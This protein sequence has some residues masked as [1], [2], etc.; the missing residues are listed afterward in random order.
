MMCRDSEEEEVF[1]FDIDSPSSRKRSSLRRNPSS[2]GSKAVSRSNS[3][4]GGGSRKRGYNHVVIVSDDEEVR[5]SNG[6]MDVGDVMGERPEA[7]GEKE[8]GVQ[9]SVKKVDESTEELQSR[10]DG[11]VQEPINLV[12]S[13]ASEVSISEQS[14]NVGKRVKKSDS[15]VEEALLDDRSGGMRAV[16]RENGIVGGD[17]IVDGGDGIADGKN[18][19][20]DGEETTNTKHD[21]PHKDTPVENPHEDSPSLE[22]SLLIDVSKPSRSTPVTEFGSILLFDKMLEDASR[23]STYRCECQLVGHNQHVPLQSLYEEAPRIVG[24]G[25]SGRVG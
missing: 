16:S 12:S 11:I 8:K 18:S 22:D 21:N 4:K 25:G 10:G 5:V 23:V 19:I 17:G 3:E 15:F 20:A 24:G 7:I 1:S 6:K 13:V 9:K 14:D 2:D